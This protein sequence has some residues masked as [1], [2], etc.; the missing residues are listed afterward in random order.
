MFSAVLGEN[1]QL[2]L[3]IQSN[4]VQNMRPNI[5]F[6][7]ISLEIRSSLEFSQTRPDHTYMHARISYAIHN[8]QYT[9]RHINTHAILIEFT[10]NLLV[11]CTQKCTKQ[12]STSANSIIRK[13]NMKNGFSNGMAYKRY[14]ILIHM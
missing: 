11:N 4:F 13:F 7:S 8:T 2:C 12:Q 14:T 10:F 1:E 6:I 9:N 5:R 3:I